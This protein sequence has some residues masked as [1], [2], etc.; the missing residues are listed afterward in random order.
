MRDPII[1]AIN[2]HCFPCFPSPS[3]KTECS[4]SVQRPIFSANEAD[5]PPACL[6]KD[7]KLVF[8]EDESS[9]SWTDEI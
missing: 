3:R 9:T 5:L 2:F 8:E 7:D 4:S 1:P 6:S